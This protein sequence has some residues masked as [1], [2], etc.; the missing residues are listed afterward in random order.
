MTLVVVA[1][2]SGGTTVEPLDRR[3]TCEPADQW[4]VSIW[5]SGAKPAV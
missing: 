4:G 3:E 5:P 1:L 2:D